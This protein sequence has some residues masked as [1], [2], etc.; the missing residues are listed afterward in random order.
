MLGRIWE[1]KMSA[2]GTPKQVEL[3]DRSLLEQQINFTEGPGQYPISNK[4]KMKAMWGHC[5]LSL[6]LY[7][8]SVVTLN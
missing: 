7:W 1:Q 6:K 4:R 2:R 3:R 8:E 5:L